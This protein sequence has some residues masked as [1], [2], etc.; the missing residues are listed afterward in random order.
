MAIN[1]QQYARELEK[2]LGMG[3]NLEKS[4]NTASKKFKTPSQ[5]KYNEVS[6]IKK[7]TKMLKEIYGGSKTYSKK[8]FSPTGRKK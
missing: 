6:L 7:V 1:R 3:K 2:Q 8:K 5:K 4:H